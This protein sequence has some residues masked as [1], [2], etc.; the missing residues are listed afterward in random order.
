[1][2]LNKRAAL[3][4]L[5]AAGL[6]MAATVAASPVSAA[7]IATSPVTGGHSS[8]SVAKTFRDA[9]SA[10]GITFDAT[11]RATY[12]HHTL[13]LPITGGK[14][15]PPAYVLKYA[16]GVKLADSNGKVK[17]TKVVAN[18]T[19]QSVSAVVN[20]GHRI[21]IFTVGLPNRG[22]GGPGMVSF[23]GYTVTLTKGAEKVLDTKLGTHTFAK[24]S[25]V[26]T[27]VTTV[28]FKA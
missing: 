26:G 4:T 17:F 20:G 19:T 22:N 10:H 3:P 21:K 11:G 8:I 5:S 6:A 13:R 16:G 7:G 25:A 15:N 18:T 24:H 14:A 1:V 2:R 9:L 23:G 27:G 12:K 28:K